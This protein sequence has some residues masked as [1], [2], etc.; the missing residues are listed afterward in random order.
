MFSTFRNVTIALAALATLVASVGAASA[1]IEL[2]QAQFTAATA[3]LPTVIET[4]EEFDPSVI[5]PSP[6]ALINGTYTA[7]D[8]QII[9]GAP[10]CPNASNCLTDGNIDGTRS[11]SAFPVNTDFWGADFQT[12]AFVGQ[13]D[14]FQVTVAGG[15]GTAVFTQ[16]V[17]GGFWGFSDPAGLTSVT[18][19]NLGNAPAG[20]AGNYSFDNVT[21]A[22]VAILEPS[23]IALPAHSYHR[24]FAG[25]GTCQRRG[26]CSHFDDV[27]LY[28][29]MHRLL[30][31]G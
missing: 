14:V 30:G 20:S 27:R 7:P 18:F 9:S 25:A 10:F 2:T 23:T 21:T 12:R 19:R 24:R 8:P 26:S 28:W 1:A 15:D 11:F 31:H 5:H 3:G 22:E 29:P 17:A 13:P 16:P 4:F 6:L